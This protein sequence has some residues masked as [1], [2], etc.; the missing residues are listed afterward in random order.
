MMRPLLQQNKKAISAIIAYVLLISITISLSVLVYNWLR[1]YVGEEEVAQCP[2]AVNVIISSYNCSLGPG[3]FLNITL[4]NKGRFSV[5]GYTLR[6]HDSPDAELGF[7]VFNETGS[8]FAPG[9]EVSSFYSFSKT[10]DGKIF[11]RLTLVE[12]QPF[13]VEESKISCKSYAYQKIVCS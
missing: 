1:F 12:V 8:A 4:K 9:E 5:D 2:D 7:Y 13:L 10:Y 11:T 3:G 6:V